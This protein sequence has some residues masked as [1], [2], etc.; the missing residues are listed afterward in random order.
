MTVT[1]NRRSFLGALAGPTIIG[2]TG[3]VRT[4][5]HKTDIRVLYF[6]DPPEA[7][8][9]SDELERF[10]QETGIS[11]DF[12]PLGYDLL[13]K[14]LRDSFTSAIPAYDVVFVDDIWLREFA[15]SGYLTNLTSLKERDLGDFERDYSETI[16]N[17][18]AF[19]PPRPDDSH[20]SPLW[21]IPHRADVQVLF[22][23]NAI[24]ADRSVEEAFQKKTGRHLHVP[25]TWDEYV[26]T[27]KGLTGIAF[28]DG[29]IT[30]CAE[31]LR[32]GHFAF[33]FFACRYWA[34]AGRSSDFFNSSDRPLFASPAG[35]NAVRHFQDLLSSKAWVPTSLNAD[36]NATLKA[37][38]DGYVALCPQ[39]YTFYRR[40]KSSVRDLGVALLPGV[41]DS[42]GHILRC[43]SIGGGS[44]GLPAKSRKHEDA[45]AFVR[46]FT[47]KPFSE[48]SAPQGA[49]VP[50]TSTYL[51]PEVRSTIPE[52][53]AY[54]SSL[55]IS[56]FRPRVAHFR[57]VETIIGN[58]ISRAIQRPK[59]QTKAIL[60]SAAAEAYA[61]IKK[62]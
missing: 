11:V 37:F 52:L 15:E 35:V 51:K 28:G 44:L 27:A 47:G 9:I 13:I 56:R 48:R 50:R 55:N 49:V 32:P 39:W 26:L 18:E 57:E 58:A 34:M 36:H 30:G 43:P 12:K 53:E 33:E 22:Y 8:F 16:L 4:P 17:A 7:Q 45:W 62:P 29:Q 38:G 25:E 61:L 46:Y 40:L 6:V 60:E 21:L 41:R 24:F 2:L 19:W 20:T 54:Q 59:E 31:T 5:S 42:D 23:N 3:C 1:M 14:E 10:Q